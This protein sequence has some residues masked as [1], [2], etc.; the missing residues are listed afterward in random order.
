MTIF[1]IKNKVNGKHASRHR[2]IDFVKGN[3]SSWTKR[4]AVI[5]SFHASIMG[6]CNCGNNLSV[7][8]LE[9]IVFDDRGI[10]NYSL[11]DFLTSDELNT[12]KNNLLNELGKSTYSSGINTVER[13]D[14]VKQDIFAKDF[15]QKNK[16]NWMDLRLKSR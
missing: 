16:A 2:G 6:Y 15:S 7:N 4:K 12:F 5:D 8:D 11:T 14:S 3:G 1:K 13:Y 9:I 10:R